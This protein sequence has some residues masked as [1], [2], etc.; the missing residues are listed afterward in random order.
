MA[1]AFGIGDIVRLKSGGPDMI[2]ESFEAN[3]STVQHPHS[4]ERLVRCL[5]MANEIVQTYVFW[6]HLLIG[7]K[8]T[9]PEAVRED[10]GR[11]LTAKE[12]ADPKAN[13]F[14]PS[15][16]PAA[17]RDNSGTDPALNR[18]GAV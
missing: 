4:A 5:W 1:E 17:N 14:A 7:D 10:L 12:R 11:T 2:I 9:E 3:P 18:D 15:Y 6:P 8:K 16:P 13:L